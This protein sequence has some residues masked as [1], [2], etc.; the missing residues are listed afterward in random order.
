MRRRSLTRGGVSVGLAGKTSLGTLLVNR[1]RVWESPSTPNGRVT[2]VVP[3]GDVEV[4][5]VLELPS[6][7]V[8]V[9]VVLPLVDD[10]LAELLVPEG[11]LVVVAI[12]VVAPL[13]PPL[14]PEEE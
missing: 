7:P 14:D 10:P 8:V 9:P 2:T 12:P 13:E 3:L 5:P 6:L 11:V 1:C 4:V